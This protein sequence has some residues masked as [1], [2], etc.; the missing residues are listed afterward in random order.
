MRL[1]TGHVRVPRRYAP[2]E[3]YL[4]VCLSELPGIHYA[5]S[6]GSN[7]KSDVDSKIVFTGEQLFRK[8]SFSTF[9][10][11]NFFV[12]EAAR[13]VCFHRSSLGCI[14]GQFNNSG[15]TLQK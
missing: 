13:A 6:T 8:T 14:K 10:F 2:L 5:F 3:G 12:F 4:T 15:T 9:F 1:G 11:F 7:A